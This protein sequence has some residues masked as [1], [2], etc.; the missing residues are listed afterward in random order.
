M[1]RIHKYIQNNI[2][3]NTFFMILNVFFWGESFSFLF[4]SVFNSYST[5]QSVLLFMHAIQLKMLQKLISTY[6]HYY[7][8]KNCIHCFH[9]LQYSSEMLEL[10]SW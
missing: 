10:P 7:K 6:S 4:L 2:Q 5:V 3:I 8:L 9:P 1:N